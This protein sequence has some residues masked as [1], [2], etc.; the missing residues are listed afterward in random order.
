MMD[1]MKSAVA[2][3]VKKKRMSQIGKGKPAV[4]VSPRSMGKMMG[5]AEMD[6]MASGPKAQGAA[7]DVRSKG[8][9]ASV[10]RAVLG[11]AARLARMK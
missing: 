3:S 7:A 9:G 11:K 5:T 4:P 10:R 8:P 6:A 2:L 1:A